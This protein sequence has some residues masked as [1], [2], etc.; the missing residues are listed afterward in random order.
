MKFSTQKTKKFFS[1][2]NK[3]VLNSLIQ[4]KATYI[5][6][7]TNTSYD[8]LY[9]EKTSETTYTE[10][11]TLNVVIATMD[12]LMSNWEE[13]GRRVTHRL[14]FLIHEDELENNSITEI[15]P[16]AIFQIKN[17]FYYKIL[18]VFDS[19]EM[20]YLFDNDLANPYKFYTIIEAELLDEE[21]A[22]E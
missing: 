3:E 12:N 1:G 6:P 19:S 20:S 8:P 15:E 13:I 16:D 10:V 22:V 5:K 17:D 2:I 7:T 11:A 18:K 21:I 4:Q 14:R 9:G